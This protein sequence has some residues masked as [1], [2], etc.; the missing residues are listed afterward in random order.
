MAET[1]S[2]GQKDK[3]AAEQATAAGANEDA[4][5]QAVREEEEREQ[6]AR[7]EAPSAA[8]LSTE[9]DT[10]KGFVVDPFPNYEDRS[11]EDL[12]SLAE[13][14][15]V[16]INRDVEKAQWVHELRTK[17][18][19][20]PASE[21]G[22]VPPNY[23]LMS[24]EDLRAVAASRDVKLPEDFEHAHLVGE[25]RAADTSVGGGLTVKTGKD[26]GKK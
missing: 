19:S 18:R 23:D 26:S 25:L 2:R 5:E 16:E 10:G 21:A 6:K 1:G 12:R 7:D 3:E 20:V 13:E 22:A 8:A 17:D 15:G 24:L 11:V 4:A 9:V 14:R